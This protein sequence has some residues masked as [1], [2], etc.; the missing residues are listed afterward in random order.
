MKR[1]MIALM[2]GAVLLTAPLMT[3][4]ATAQNGGDVPG[5]RMEKLAKKLNLSEDQRSQL[6]GI[7]TRTATKIRA[8]L[9]PEQQAKFD[10]AK[11]EQQKRREAMKANGGRRSEGDEPNPQ[12]VLR[13]L[14]LTDS[15][16][17]QMK[18]IQAA[19]K[20]EMDGVLTASQKAQ[21][22]QLKQQRQGRRGLRRPG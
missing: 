6:N 22:E 8:I 5:P 18:E 15:Q 7:R 16:K 3:N 13:S 2:A 9:T 1:Q 17:A 19:A 20:A 14:N 12:G 10:A 11:A 4:M 21:L